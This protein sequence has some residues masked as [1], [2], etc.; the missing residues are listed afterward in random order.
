[1]RGRIFSN[2]GETIG[3]TPLVRLN[4]LV[5]ATMAEVCVKLE[6]F[7]PGGSVKD[8]I[9]LSMIEAAEASGELKKGMEIIEPTSGNTGIALAMVAAA[10]G[11]EL[12]L[13]MPDTMSSERRRLLEA[14][15]AKLVLTP[16]SKGMKGAI[17][18]AEKL[19]RESGN[20]FMP[21]Q[22]DNPANP[23]VHRTTTA[24]EVVRDTDGKLDAF[25]CGVGTGGT[26]AGVGAVLKGA[27][28]SR[29]L[30]VAVE[31]A[32]SPVLSGGAPGPHK[33]QGIGAGFVPANYDP[34]VVDR[35]VQVTYDD[36]V[37]R[38]RDLARMEGILVGIS[39]GAI[40]HAALQVARELGPGKRVVSVVCDN[41]ERYLST[42]LFPYEEPAAA[43]EQESP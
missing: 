40:L 5:D 31:P 30:V 41:G 36:A 32:D 6:Y 38:A 2:I 15:G 17:A 4:R 28:G 26:A 43:V 3:A 20:A 11:Y 21:S 9:G 19:A 14:Y 8:R 39:S 12:T 29:V 1:M 22:F 18:H 37:A 35:V 13:V 16:G 10:R 34:S 42:P 7:N 25:V 33:I 27:V 23:A 24:V